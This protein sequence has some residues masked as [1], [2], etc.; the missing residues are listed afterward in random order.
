M[1]RRLTLLSALFSLMALAAQPAFANG[2]T[3]LGT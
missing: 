3:N 2:V 1:K